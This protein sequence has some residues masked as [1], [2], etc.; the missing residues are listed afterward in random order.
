VNQV[1]FNDNLRLWKYVLG[2]S[3]GSQW[4]H[5]AVIFKGKNNQ[6]DRRL[7]GRVATMVKGV[8]ERYEWYEDNTSTEIIAHVEYVYTRMPNGLAISQDGETFFYNTDGTTHPQTFKTRKVYSPL[9]QMDE[10]VARRNNVVKQI[11]IETLGFIALLVYGGDFDA[12]E[13]VALPYLAKHSQLISVYV[14]GG[15]NITLQAAIEADTESWL[16]TDLT[17]LGIPGTTLKQYIKASFDSI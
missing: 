1:E 14:Q 11:S 9:E 7:D 8:V 5:R 2:W 17:P 13:S 3:P 6:L 15:D 12:A 16:S 10:A 4:D